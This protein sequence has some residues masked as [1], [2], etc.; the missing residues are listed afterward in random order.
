MD[1]GF[2][3]EQEILKSTARNFLS[4]ECPKSLVREM[5]DD[6]KGY[7]AELWRKMA[8]L[9]WM[10]LIVPEEYGGIGGNF[11]DLSIL[12]EVMG[13]ACLPGPFFSTA[14]LGNL[15]I[16]AGGNEEQK[17]TLLPK[18][19][20]GD[21]I[22]SLALTEPGLWYDLSG[23]ATS[24]TADKDEYIINGT[25]IFV[26]N[27]HIAD[28]IICAACTRK[29]DGSEE[30][31][32]LFLIDGK[33]AGVKYTL[34]K[35]FA[36]DKQCEVVFN[37]VR[38][39]KENILGEKGQASLV[40]DKIMEQAAIAKCAEMVGIL[41][42][43]LEMTVNYTKEREQFGRPIG[44]FQAIQHHCAN[45]V[46][47]VDGSRFITYKAAWK[48][49]EGLPATMEI[50]M[51]K[52]WT[53]KASRRVTQLGH[54]IHGAIAF[55]EEHDMHLYYRRA[56]TGEVLFGDIDYNMEIVAQQLGL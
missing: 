54:Q 10:G 43:T 36:D 32:T 52:A 42:A 13:E 6:E 27:A 18:I 24:A 53:N 21:L 49:S 25:K 3:E 15:A 23:I 56:K 28:Y 31:L 30:G 51:A 14:V 41:H 50:A 26:E 29:D 55:C 17:R 22:L 45:M 9:G 19:A 12:L 35:T 44:S 33:S 8:D 2:N 47:D 38:V 7:P 4:N 48:L 46:T 5:R 1:L 11:L 40:L 39:A 20:K 37:N 16:L 34:L